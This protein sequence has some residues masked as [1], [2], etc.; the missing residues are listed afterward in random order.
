MKANPLLRDKIRGESKIRGELRK[1]NKQE[2][3]ALAVAASLFLA[4]LEYLLPKPVPFFRFGL[5]N[6]VLLVLLRKIKGTDMYLVLLFRVVA[7]GVIHGTIASYVFLFSL[8]G[9]VTS[10]SVV[11]LVSKIFKKEISL[12]GLSVVGAGVSNSVQI[13]C[14]VFFVFGRT[15]IVIAPYL[16]FLGLCSGLIVGI[17]ATYYTNHS[18][19]L[20]EFCRRYRELSNANRPMQKERTA[21]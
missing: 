14:S 19:F 21:V 17:L 16:L 5:S 6:I 15:S 20:S 13:L 7:T 4:S 3:L 8:S 11:L 18:L 12:L 9:S 1:L 10:L 2:L